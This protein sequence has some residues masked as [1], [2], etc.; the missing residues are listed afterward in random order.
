MSRQQWKVT[1]LILSAAFVIVLSLIFVVP[2]PRAM[3][4]QSSLSTCSDVRPTD[5]YFSD[6]QSLMDRYGVDV[7]RHD[8]TVRQY[9]AETRAD[10]ASLLAPA[11]ARIDELI[12]GSGKQLPKKSELDNLN[13]LLEQVTAQ[14]E[15]LER[16]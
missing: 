7:C 9:R 14:V 1:A 16:R 5:W 2:Y 13:Q 3:F 11:I 12:K 10:M 8:R 15:I 6:A 4:A